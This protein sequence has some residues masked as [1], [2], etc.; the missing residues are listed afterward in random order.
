MSDHLP[1]FVELKIDFTDQY[2][3]RVREG[4]IPIDRPRADASGS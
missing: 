2:L 1:L 4:E 3:T